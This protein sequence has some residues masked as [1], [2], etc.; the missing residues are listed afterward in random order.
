MTSLNCSTKFSE[1]YIR[2]SRRTDLKDN[3]CTFESDFEEVVCSS[4]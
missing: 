2:Y 1:N 4:G 3:L